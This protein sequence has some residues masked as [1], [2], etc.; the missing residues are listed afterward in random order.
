MH[1]LALGI[2]GLLLAGVC[3]AAAALAGL[4]AVAGAVAT[5][6]LFS[7]MP[8]AAGEP[9]DDFWYGTTLSPAE[10]A[11]QAAATGLPHGRWCA[12]PP[13]SAWAPYQVRRPVLTALSLPGASAPSPA[14][15]GPLAPVYRTG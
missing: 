8:A 11:T 12:A 5:A 4:R 14:P 6:A 2:T 1:H 7:T 3:L 15:A 9:A 13:G 10:A